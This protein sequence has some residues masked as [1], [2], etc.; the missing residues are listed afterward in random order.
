MSSHSLH[1]FLF[2]G[3]IVLLIASACD[4]N[5]GT[6]ELTTNTN[7]GI[8]ESAVLSGATGTIYEQPVDPNGRLLLSSWRDPDGSDNDQYVWD[9]FT[10]QSN[11]TITEVNWFGVYDPLRFGAGGPVLD[12]SV[13]IF[14]SIAAGTEPDIAHP[15]LVRYQA[16]GNASESAI[17]TAGGGTLYAY[18]FPLPAPF[19]AT[20]GTRYWLQIEGF[21]HGSIPD[22]CL[23]PGRGGDSSHFL[24]TSGVGGDIL[25]RFAPG[26]A[27]FAL[28]GLIPDI[29]TPT[30]TPTQTPTDTL[31]PTDTPTVQVSTNTPTDTPTSTPTFI[32]GTDTPTGVQTSTDTPT[33]TPTN[34]PAETS[35]SMP[36]P[37]E[38]PTATDTP[39]ST[40]TPLLSTPG[41]VTGGGNID[42]DQNDVK[43]TFGFTIDYNLG[44]S[45]PSG[46]LTYQD[47]KANL[48][49]KA[50]SFD[51]LLIDGNH[52][53]ITGT[54]TTDDGQLVSFTVE[55]D[56][57][58]NLGASDMFY[59]SIPALN[60]YAFGG[61]IN[62]GNITIH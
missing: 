61:V 12:F 60:G 58:G 32:Q 28:I 26:D 22:W 35:T 5:T 30:D 8:R 54:G 23:A 14:P 34:L 50:T 48:R 39:T 6:Q 27:A 9:S 44:D 59:I 3:L 33:T 29:P 19:V 49:L 42:S 52:V 17:G 24:R 46:N 51:L 37:M 53:Q 10:L 1:R 13:S 15:P 7:L 36:T 2:F 4:A 21:Q 55:M 57:L 11:A 40:P 38:T 25:Y 20:A 45:A 16:G 56:A 43:A 31:T 18:T 41:K 62:G 47:H